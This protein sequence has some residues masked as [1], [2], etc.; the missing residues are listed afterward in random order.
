MNKQIPAD[1]ADDELSALVAKEHG[2]YWDQHEYTTRNLTN[3][4]AGMWRRKDSDEC[5][6]LP[7]Y[8]TSVDRVLTVLPKFGLR[9]D[10]D[11]DW[12]VEINTPELPHSEGSAPTLARAFCFC[13]LTS[14]GFTIT[15]AKPTEGRT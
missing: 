15:P 8:A 1:I 2:W 5:G 4:W 3:Y 7:K 9:I 13:I 11:G 14:K 12:F 6:D 10:R